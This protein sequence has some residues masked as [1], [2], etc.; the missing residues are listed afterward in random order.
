MS[1]S[2]PFEYDRRYETQPDGSLEST[3]QAYEVEEMTERDLG[4]LLAEIVFN[5]VSTDPSA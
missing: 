1:H 2:R 5:H 4:R 3:L